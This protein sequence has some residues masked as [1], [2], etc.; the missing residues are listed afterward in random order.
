MKILDNF[1]DEK[2]FND[3]KNQI[4]AVNFPFYFVDGVTDDKNN[5]IDHFYFFH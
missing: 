4:S 5:D 1:L 3:L 2:Y